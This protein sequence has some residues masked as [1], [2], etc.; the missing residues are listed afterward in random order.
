M[1]VI[2]DTAPRPMHRSR[3]IFLM[4]LGSRLH[5]SSK[6]NPF[7]GHAANCGRAGPGL[8]VP[9][10]TG[11]SSPPHACPPKNN[12]G[13]PVRLCEDTTPY[14][15]RSALLP[16]LLPSFLPVF[17]FNLSSVQRS[18]YC[19]YPRAHDHE[20]Y[21]VLVLQKVLLSSH[22]LGP[23]SSHFSSATARSLLGRRSLFP[24]SES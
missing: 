16:F 14:V 15:G 23:W 13:E 19:M 5:T 12:T 3:C 9:S 6:P 10:S 1:A 21:S 7:S 2:T 20:Y 22:W 18:P 11:V 24:S 4:K 17:S 8:A